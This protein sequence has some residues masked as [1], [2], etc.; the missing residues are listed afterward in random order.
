MFP[1]LVC[2]TVLCLLCHILDDNTFFDFLL[3][4]SILWKLLA[5]LRHPDSSTSCSIWGSGLSCWNMRD[6]PRKIHWLDGSFVVLKPVY[7]FQYWWCLPRFSS[8]QFNG[9]W[10]TSKPSY[11]CSTDGDSWKSSW[12]FYKKSPDSLNFFV[13]SYTVDD[14]I[15]KVFI[16][17][18]WGTLLWKCS[19]IS[20]FGGFFQIFLCSYLHKRNSKHAIYTQL[21][22]CFVHK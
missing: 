5:A 8:C 3:N 11:P 17:F 13:T 21:C 1:I 14:E 4:V 2:S 18:C 20:R 22:Y 7:S 15:F 12:V 16:I 6:F 10:F 19:T 9:H